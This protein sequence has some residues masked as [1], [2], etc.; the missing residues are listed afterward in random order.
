MANY[1]NAEIYV[2][3]YKGH[4]DEFIERLKANYNYN[5][6]EF[7]THKHFFRIFDV[8]VY[9]EYPMKVHVKPNLYGES[10]CIKR[11]D[12]SIECAWSVNV[13]MFPGPHT[14]Y[15]DFI[16]VPDYNKPRFMNQPW[17]EEEIEEN[18]R[19]HSLAQEHATNILLTCKELELDVEIISLEPGMCFSEHYFVNHDGE[20]ELEEESDYNEYF[21]D[22]CEDYDQFIEENIY[23]DPEKYEDD[24][25]YKDAREKAE[26]IISEEKFDLL[27][28]EG[29]YYYAPY[30]PYRDID[31]I[32]DHIRDNVST[33][34][35]CKLV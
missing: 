30:D 7:D 33:T 24:K 12:I 31:P 28:K 15:N 27:K 20:I 3:G 2:R 10:N 17:T 13:C 5:K 1:C 29:T 34:D 4:V 25:Q 21:I 26:S 23:Y 16:E 22:D 9:D 14:Y 19:R 35:M 6:E 11:A 32:M 18:K 8:N